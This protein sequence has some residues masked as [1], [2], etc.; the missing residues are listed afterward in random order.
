[1][2]PQ[3]T[4]PLSPATSASERSAECSKLKF[5]ASDRFIRD[6][7]R[8]VDGY[9]E[10]TG[11]RRRDCAQMY[12]KTA[13]ILAWFLAAYI[14]LLFVVTSWWA[15]VPLAIVLGVSIA[16]IGF[17]VQHDGGH[18]AYSERQWVNKIMAMT[19]DMMG[20]SSYLWDWKHNSIHHTFP[21]IDGHDDDINVGLLARLSPHQKR[22]PFHR[23]QGIYLWMLYGF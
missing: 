12:F 20:G 18:K 2:H 11:H 3:P 17:N 16:A 6:L 9:F 15:V 23:A 7:R 13:T 5:T 10:K 1:M 19:L 8:R 21:N 4:V 22:L 14:L